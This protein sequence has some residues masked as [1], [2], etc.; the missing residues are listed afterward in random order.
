MDAN[1]AQ[2]LITNGPQLLQF[3]DAHGDNF[4]CHL[5]VNVGGRNCCP[6]CSLDHA[7]NITLSPAPE[8]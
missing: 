6:N 1:E 8:T 3:A 5:L 2:S 7:R 4:R